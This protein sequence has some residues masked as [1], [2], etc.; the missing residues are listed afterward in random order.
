M[1]SR[2]MAVWMVFAVG[3][4]AIPA[5]AEASASLVAPSRLV[6]GTTATLRISGFPSST[7]V[8]VQLG[9]VFNPLANC[10]ASRV[11]PP[12]GRPALLTGPTGSLQFAWPVPRTYERCIDVPCERSPPPH[13]TLPYEPGQKVIIDVVTDDSSAYASA[14]AT[15]VAQPD[16]CST[17]YPGGGRQRT[18]K[19]FGGTQ[20][21]FDREASL[22]HVCEGFGAPDRQGF[23]L[24]ET[25]KCA[26]IAAAATYGGPAVNKGVSRACDA[27]EIA[28][29][30]SSGHWLGAAQ[31]IGCGYF[32]DI[33]AGGVGVF[34]AGATAETG[35]GAVAVGVGTYK[36]L[37]AGLKLVCGGIFQGAGTA[38]G[39]RL[40]A[41]HETV[42]VA[43]D[44]VRHR[45]CIRLTRR[46][47][48]LHW[49][50]H[51]C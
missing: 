10:C 20:T 32:S 41:N 38:L 26:I 30:L 35:P 7:G 9:R 31:S 50:A 18:K 24:T 48:Q 34:V 47:G 13:N 45:K 46:F 8:R 37:A 23:K 39:H 44:V 22:F 17:R 36:A 4:A 49:T 42:H 33:F 43:I 1:C 14:R 15:I 11:Y 12:L 3:W 16:P 40:E 27:A 28:R 21:L 29:N 2:F 51:N 25:M 19:T 5:S 6:P